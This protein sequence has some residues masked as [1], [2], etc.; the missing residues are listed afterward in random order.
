MT[1]VGDDDINL[2]E[3]G[4]SD[5]QVKQ[6]PR[7]QVDNSSPTPQ[8]TAAELKE[9]A[10]EI[11]TTVR[12]V[13]TR[14]LAISQDGAESDAAE[15]QRL[16]TMVVMLERMLE[17]VRSE[18]V[19]VL[20]GAINID[21]MVDERV[22]VW[23]KTQRGLL[24]AIDKMHQNKYPPWLIAVMVLGVAVI[25]L[26]AANPEYGQS[27]N[28]FMQNPQNQVFIVVAMLIAAGIVYLVVRRRK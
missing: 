3:S 21:R 4:D 17:A 13:R 20:R 5:V 15:V 27:L 24:N 10:D 14:L 23:S 16:K 7:K 11:E 19:G 9:T 28:Q 1:H 12:Q 18:L 26:F 22:L 2:K 8:R 6:K 25:A